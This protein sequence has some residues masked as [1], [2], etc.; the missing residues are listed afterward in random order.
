MWT[1]AALRRDLIASGNERL[2][3]FRP[4]E[5]EVKLRELILTMGGEYA[6]H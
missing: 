6:S 1:D 5:F 2:F 4:E 3:L